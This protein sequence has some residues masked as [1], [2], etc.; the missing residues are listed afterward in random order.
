MN[1]FDFRETQQRCAAGLPAKSK[2]QKGKG[3]KR[4]METCQARLSLHPRDRPRRPAFRRSIV[5]LLDSLDWI[6][7]S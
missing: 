1:Q 4:K 6:L 2:K 7:S 3:K 5:E